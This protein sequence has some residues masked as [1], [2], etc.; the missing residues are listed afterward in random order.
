VQPFIGRIQ[1]SGDNDPNRFETHSPGD[2]AEQDLRIMA[3]SR[4][5]QRKKTVKSTSREIGSPMEIVKMIK[6]EL[7]KSGMD[8]YFIGKKA[9]DFLARVYFPSVN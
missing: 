5:L 8:A 3:A 1:R 4:F 6:E 2:G 7:E 9:E